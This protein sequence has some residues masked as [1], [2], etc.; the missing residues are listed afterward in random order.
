MSKKSPFDIPQEMKKLVLHACCAPCSSAIIEFL[1]HRQIEPIV[2]FFNPN[3]VPFDEY[4]HRKSEL[5]RYLN[6]FKIQFIDADYDHQQ[7][8]QSIEG[9]EEEPERGKRCAACFSFRLA[10]TALFATQNNIRFFTTTLTSSR[11]KDKNQIFTAGEQ[12]QALYPTTVF[13]KMD[14]KKGGLSERRSQIIKEQQFY[15]QQYCGCEFGFFQSV[16]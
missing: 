9:L 12:A 6:L 5:I 7:W 15:N 10:K 13:W 4:Q 8:L 1:H 14:W 16:E 2:F 11:W 3:I